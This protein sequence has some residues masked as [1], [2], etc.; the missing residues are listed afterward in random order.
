[1]LT[2]YFNKVEK[3][4]APY[5]IFIQFHILFVKEKKI[6]KINMLTVKLQVELEDALF[7]IRDMLDFMKLRYLFE[8][9]L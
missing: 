2:D 8:I 7:V 5:V 3:S 1:M 9:L 6:R 4:T